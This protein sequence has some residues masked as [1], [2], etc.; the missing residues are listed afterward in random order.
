MANNLDIIIG[1]NI[2]RARASAGM[3][4]EELGKHLGIRAQQISKFELGINRVSSSQLIGMAEQLRVNVVDLMTGVSNELP[5][6][7][8]DAAFMRDYKS[9]SDNTKSTVRELVRA[10]ITDTARRLQ[11]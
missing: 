4:Q 6:D 7:K 9:L 1:E 8:G 10:I 11:Q 5:T 2:R 3:S